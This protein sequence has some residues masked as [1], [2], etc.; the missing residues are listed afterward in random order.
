MATGMR[1]WMLRSRVRKLEQW[2]ALLVDKTEN[3]SITDR[4]SDILVLKIGVATNVTVEG[5]V[6][7]LNLL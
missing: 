4:T 5:V 1:N 7:K 3:P 2:E 6:C